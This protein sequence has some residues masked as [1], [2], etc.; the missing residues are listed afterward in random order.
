M[1]KK[2][3]DAYAASTYSYAASIPMTKPICKGCLSA[4]V[5][6]YYS[7]HAETFKCPCIICIIKIVCE[8][9]CEEFGK[10]RDKTLDR[11]SN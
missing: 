8:R 5:D 9:G 6:C 4:E 7:T 1:Y 11:R 10:F 3:N 2:T